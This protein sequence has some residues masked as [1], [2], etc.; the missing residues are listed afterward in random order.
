MRPF[1]LERPTITPGYGFVQ[2]STY[3]GF[4]STV[5]CSGV[6]LQGGFRRA[7]PG[8]RVEWE[9]KLEVKKKSILSHLTRIG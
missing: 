1:P 3:N 2:V 7:F 6:D 8:G 5:D 4:E 9:I